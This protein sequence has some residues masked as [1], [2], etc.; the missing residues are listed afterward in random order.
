MRAIHE[1][2]RFDDRH[3][4]P[5]LAKRRV[6]RQSLCIRID[7]CLR[8]DVVANRNYG[9]PFCKPRA[10][11]SIFRQP[12]AQSVETFRDFFTRKIRH[13]LGALVHL[14]PRDDPLILQRLDE[15][16]SVARLLSDRFVEQNHAAD[17]FA[18][19]LRGKQD[20]AICPPVFF[21]RRNVD[22]F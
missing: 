7:A 6:T 8:R 22:A 10:K 12:V 19:V 20:L 5:F 11:F 16:A 21:C 3:Q 4:I 17:K 9:T 18:G 14:D 1:H 13:R 15:S 2:F